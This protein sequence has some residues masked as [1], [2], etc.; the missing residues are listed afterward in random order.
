MRS[1]RGR[2]LHNMVALTEHLQQGHLPQ[3]CGGH[4]LLLHLQPACRVSSARSMRCVKRQA[5]RMGMR[6]SRRV[7]FSATS[8]AVF[9]SRAL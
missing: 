9:F 6:A 1:S 4:A 7:F 2:A 3:R 8:L 5:V